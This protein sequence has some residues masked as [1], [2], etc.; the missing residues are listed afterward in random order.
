MIQSSP[1]ICALRLPSPQ[2]RNGRPPSVAPRRSPT[3]APSGS[4]AQPHAAPPR[5]AGGLR[6]ARFRRRDR[7]RLPPRTVRARRGRALRRRM[8]AGRLRH[9]AL[10]A[11][12]AGARR[13]S[14]APLHPRVRPGRGHRDPL[15]RAHVAPRG[16]GDGGKVDFRVTFAT[17]IFGEHLRPARARG[18]GR[19]PT[20][21]RAS[22]GARSR[23]SRACARA[24]GSSARPRC[25][26]GRR[27]RRATA[28][29]SPSG[30]ARLSELG[31]LASEIAGRVGP[32]P[33]E[34][35]EE[36]ARRGIP[37]GTKSMT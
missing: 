31:P 22:R 15:A 2:P 35:E 30:E 32:A 34:R 5:T 37:E 29:S 28:R 26:R 9:D 21:R 7:D 20:A 13:V 19:A 14:A 17:R 8:G 25:R 10:A 16:C 27:S 18:R 6:C 3:S 36:L 4:A 24:S 23:S 1:V 11:D 33:P 12:G